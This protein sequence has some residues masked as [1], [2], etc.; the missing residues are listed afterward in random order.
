MET[1]EKKKKFDGQGAQSF[2]ND[3]G[4]GSDHQDSPKCRLKTREI[5]FESPSSS[6][7]GAPR[8]QTGGRGKNDEK[9]QAQRK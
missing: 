7:L 1:V 3:F 6:A 2:K 8:A 5:T 9:R 4:T